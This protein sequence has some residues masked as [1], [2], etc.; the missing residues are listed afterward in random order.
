MYRRFMWG[1]KSSHFSLRGMEGGG[2]E[3]PGKAI[4]VPNCEKQ[5]KF[6]NSR[7]KQWV[8]I[9]RLNKAEVKVD[10]RDHE[11]IER[12]EKEESQTLAIFPTDAPRQDPG[13][14]RLQEHPPRCTKGE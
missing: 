13:Y 7:P 6:S 3:G 2:P 14:T 8:V 10:S 1:F 5:D 4:G 11:D 12:N 9:V